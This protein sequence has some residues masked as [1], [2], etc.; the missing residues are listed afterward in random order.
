[1]AP[2]LYLNP[3]RVGTRIT[4]MRHS[5][6]RLGDAPAIFAKFAGMGEHRAAFHM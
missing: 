2:E 4:L 6:L 5:S 1:M 3:A